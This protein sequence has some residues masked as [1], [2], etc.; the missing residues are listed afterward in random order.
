MTEDVTVAV[1]VSEAVDT[2]IAVAELFGVPG[3]LSSPPHAVAATQMTSTA[4]EIFVTALLQILDRASDSQVVTSNVP[5]PSLA[6]PDWRSTA[7]SRHRPTYTAEVTCHVPPSSSRL[8]LQTA[9]VE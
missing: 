5:Q 7:W 8:S 2:V 9:S 4:K 6:P 1:A 3:A